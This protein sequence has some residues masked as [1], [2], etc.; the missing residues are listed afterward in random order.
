MARQYGELRTGARV[1]DA[2][3]KVIRSGHDTRA[4]GRIRGAN[5]QTAV[6]ESIATCEPLRASQIRAVP[7]CNPVTIWMLSGE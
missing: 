5:D 3:D 4:V 2:R 1:P 6:A 7:S